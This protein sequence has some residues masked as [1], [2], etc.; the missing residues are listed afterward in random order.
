MHTEDTHVRARSLRRLSVDELGAYALQEKLIDA[1]EAFDDR[2]LITQ[3]HH[4]FVLPPRQAVTFLIGMLRGRT[5]YADPPGPALAK[6][7]TG[8][9]VHPRESRSLDAAERTSF[10]PTLESLLAFASEVGIIEGFGWDRDTHTVRI[11][12]SACSTQLS[13]ADAL[14]YLFD[15]VQH[16]MRLLRS[17]RNTPGGSPPTLANE[18]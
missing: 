1:I 9:F 5:W 14:H 16:E 11:D 12:I 3:G 8:Q 4:R 17:L 15:C 10:R 13:D 7:E 18:Q 2:V 6:T